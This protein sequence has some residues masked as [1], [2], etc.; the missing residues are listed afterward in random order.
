MSKSIFDVIVPGAGQDGLIISYYLSLNGFTL[1]A[2]EHEK[3]G[4]S[5]LNK[6]GIPSII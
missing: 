3:T 4:N 5:C 1:T 2:A 6:E